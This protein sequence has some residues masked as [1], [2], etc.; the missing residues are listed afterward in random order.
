MSAS[1]N[2]TMANPLNRNFMILLF[3]LA[4]CFKLKAKTMKNTMHENTEIPSAKSLWPF[5]AKSADALMLWNQVPLARGPEKG[6]KKYRMLMNVSCIK[7][8]GWVSIFH[9]IS[10]SLQA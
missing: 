7:A 8:I 4:K 10:N 9:K 2:K 5:L 1:V 6:E 3:W